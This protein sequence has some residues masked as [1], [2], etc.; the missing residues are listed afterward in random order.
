M[1]AWM[2][3][4]ASS[5]PC[6]NAACSRCACTVRSRRRRRRAAAASVITSSRLNSSS[7]AAPGV[8]SN[9]RRWVL[10]AAKRAA[11]PAATQPKASHATRCGRHER[12]RPDQ[13]QAERDEDRELEPAAPRR[14]AQVAVVEQVLEQ[15]RVQL[16]A[17]HRLAER[18]GAVVVAQAAAGRADQHELARQRLR[19]DLAGEHV[20]GRDVAARVAA[21]VVQASARRRPRSAR[22]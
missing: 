7:S 5:S 18:R 17:R 22:W 20:G 13:Q 11:P 6:T 14:P 3:C 12:R 21:R 1:P 4:A 10:N 2:R 15:L 8:A 16:A 9:S 19:V